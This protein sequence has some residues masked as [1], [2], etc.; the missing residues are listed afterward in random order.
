MKTALL[1][2][3]WWL[4][5][6]GVLISDAPQPRQ[7]S[8]VLVV[9]RQREFG[10]KPYAITLNGKEVG[11]LS[12]NRYLKLNTPAGRAKIESKKGYLSENQTIWLT[13]QPGRT[14]YIK[15]VEEVD[16]LTQTLL[17]A[18][19]SEEQARQELRRVKPVE[20]APSAQKD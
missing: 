7:E 12:P 9:Y 2:M 18:P 6:T 4:L 5:T 19:V 17:L 8:A 13:L 16:F 3:C 11:S 15:A 1:L 20:I 14:H 10:G